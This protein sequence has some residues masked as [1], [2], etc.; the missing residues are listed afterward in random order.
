LKVVSNTSPIINLAAI[1]QLELLNKLFGNIYIPIEVYHEISIKGKGQPGSIEAEEFNWIHKKSL[2]TSDNLVKAL[3]LELDAGEAEAI[4]LSLEQK[5]DLL[6]ID[7]RRGRNMA[8]YYGLNYIG[9]L[10]VLLL[11]KKKSFI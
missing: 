7:E 11:A 4:A 1:G 5:A 6:L 10:G 8:E 9:I 3:K 2:D